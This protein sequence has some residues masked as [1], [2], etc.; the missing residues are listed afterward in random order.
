MCI[1]MH[2]ASNKAGV[3]H[4]PIRCDVK[5]LLRPV[6]PLYHGGLIT[7]IFHCAID[8]QQEGCIVYLA[9]HFTGFGTSRL[10]E[11]QATLRQAVCV[12]QA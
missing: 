10:F 5:T 6:L 11:S 2:A 1:C 4:L 9:L 12:L 3:E 7:S 8:E